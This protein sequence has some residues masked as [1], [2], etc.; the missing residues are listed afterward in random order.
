MT[1]QEA[2]GVL[3]GMLQEMMGENKNLAPVVEKA[4]ALKMAIEDLKEN[5]WVPMVTN[6]Q[7]AIINP[8]PEDGEDVLISIYDSTCI[9]SFGCDFEYDESTGDGRYEWFLEDHD[10]EDVKAWR[11]L[12]KPWKGEA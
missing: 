7:G 11:P 12:P 10:I 8:L 2:I 3:E 4:I 9:D 5:A 1:T 6:E